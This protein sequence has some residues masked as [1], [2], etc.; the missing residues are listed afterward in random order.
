METETFS[1]WYN[2]LFSEIERQL[3]DL[4]GWTGV[5]S[6]HINGPCL[7]IEVEKYTEIVCIDGQVRLL[8]SNGYHYSLSAIGFD[9]LCLL[10]DRLYKIDPNAAGA[11]E[12]PVRILTGH[13]IDLS[14]FPSF[15]VTGDVEGMRLIYGKGALLVRFGKNIYHVSADPGIYFKH[16]QDMDDW[17]W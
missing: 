12:R 5:P 13:G 4:T 10:A 3:S 11:V 2:Y 15:S 9:E 1:G 17:I 6:A 8:D 7:K 14:D 16:S